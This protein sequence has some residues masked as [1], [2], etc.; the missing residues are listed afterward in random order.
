MAGIE[1][2]FLVAVAAGLLSFLSP[3]VLPLFPSYVS[4]IAGVSFEELQGGATSA[5][6]RR[7]ILVNSLLFILGF[8]LVFIALGAGASLAGQLLFRYQSLIRKIGG[9]FVILMGL[10]IAGWL[11]IPFLM[12]EFRV[13]AA[14][15]PAGYVGSLVAGFTFAAGWTPCIGPILGSILT[16]ASVSQTAGSGILMLCA[17]SLGLAVPFLACSLAIRR[18]LVFFDRFK[19]FL[20]LVTRG[21]GLILLAVGLLLITDYFTVLSR[22]A[23]SLTPEWL[24]ELEK[25]LLGTR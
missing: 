19:R 1:L 11:R 4:I 9:A 2:N 16:M 6:T 14:E 8:S 17:Y 10:Y 18:F 7:A 21:S 23:F 13:H 15:R 25:V 24:F 20:P 5:R 22:F 3:C 12:R